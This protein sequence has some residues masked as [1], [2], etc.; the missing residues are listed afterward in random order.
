MFAD[1]KLK[2]THFYPGADIKTFVKVHTTLFLIM[3]DTVYRQGSILCYD[4]TY[5]Y[6]YL[7]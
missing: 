7:Q 2:E 6:L 3:E 4:Q 1:N 5:T